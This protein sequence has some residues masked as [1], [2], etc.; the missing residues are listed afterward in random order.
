MS[1]KNVS[2]TRHRLLFVLPA[3]LP[4]GRV[5]I[6]AAALSDVRVDAA[7]AEG[8]Q[9]LKQRQSGRFRIFRLRNFVGVTDVLG[10]QAARSAQKSDHS[11][12]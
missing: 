9:V 12:L 11:P 6:A 4:A 7:E 5:D 10:T 8:L 3:Q 1:A 2:Y